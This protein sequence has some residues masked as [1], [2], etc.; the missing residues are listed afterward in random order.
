MNW[1]T[2]EFLV[3]LQV[4]VVCLV[5]L[6]GAVDD[7]KNRLRRWLK[8]KGNIS[9][10]P[11]DCSLCT[12]HWVALI[13]L[14]CMGELTLLSYMVVCLLALATIITRTAIERLFDLILWLLTRERRK[15]S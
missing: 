5:D 14:L 15:R 1:L 6:S 7:F 11:F 10:K 12:Y 3:E 9:I 13:V 8:V 2:F 4:V